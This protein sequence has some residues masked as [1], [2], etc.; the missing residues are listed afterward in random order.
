MF[1]IYNWIVSWKKNNTEL[2]IS[3]YIVDNPQLITLWGQAEPDQLWV[4]DDTGAIKK[5]S[6]T[7]LSRFYG[8][9]EVNIWSVSSM[10]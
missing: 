7:L 4:T 2:L 6:R 3:F 10:F 8:Y 9:T 1:Y 5:Y